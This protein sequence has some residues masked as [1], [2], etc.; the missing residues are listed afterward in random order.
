MKKTYNGLLKVML[1]HEYEHALTI[2]PLVGDNIIIADEVTGR[3]RCGYKYLSVR[4]FVSENP[5][6][7]EEEAQE[8]LLNRIYGVTDASYWHH[9][10]ELTGYLFTDENLIVG[11]HDLLKELQ[12]FVGNFIL[13]EIDYSKTPCKE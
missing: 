6:R 9:Y 12:S 10:S 4:Y 3:V 2:I 1:D 8:K 5:I 13:L 11:G 7:N